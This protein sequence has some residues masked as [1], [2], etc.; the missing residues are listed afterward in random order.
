VAGAA[1]DHLDVLVI[2]LLLSVG[3]MGVAANF[4]ARLLEKYRWIAYIGLLI[5]VYVAVTMIWHGG[6]DVVKVLF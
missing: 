1:R 3:L 4:I 5:V 2:G 6:A